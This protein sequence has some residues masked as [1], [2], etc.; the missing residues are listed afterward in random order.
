[1]S[2][3]CRNIVPSPYDWWPYEMTHEEDER[4]RMGTDREYDTV[5]YTDQV[6]GKIRK[7]DQL[8]YF[9]M[10]A[11]AEEQ[12]KFGGVLG[13]VRAE[14]LFF[15]KNKRIVAIWDRRS[16]SFRNADELAKFNKELL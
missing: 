5:Y 4:R 1:M 14:S 7:M 9:P 15:F 13:N 8:F 6:H 16:E 10:D 3:S 12:V 11:V 2:K